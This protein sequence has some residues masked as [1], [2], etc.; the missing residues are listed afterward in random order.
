MRE[1]DK[2]TRQW[3]ESLFLNCQHRLNEVIDHFKNE[4]LELV[5][6]LKKD[7]LNVDANNIRE[8]A[9]KYKNLIL[10]KKYEPLFDRYEFEV[11]GRIKRY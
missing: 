11:K 10:D 7:M 9:I 3:L 8:L 5:E 4:Q 2:P 6:E 1:L